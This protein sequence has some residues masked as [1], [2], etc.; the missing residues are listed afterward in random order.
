[1]IEANDL[2][3]ARFRVFETLVEQIEAALARRK[4]LPS[5]VSRTAAAAAATKTARAERAAADKQRARDEEAKTAA[6]SPSPPVSIKARSE[7]AHA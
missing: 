1:M 5:A 2:R 3:W 7:A 6:A 4:A